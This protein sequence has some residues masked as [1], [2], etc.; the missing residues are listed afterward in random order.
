M[1]VVPIFTALIRV[2]V[3]RSMISLFSFQINAQALLNPLVGLLL[4]VESNVWMSFL[5]LLLV[6]LIPQIDMLLADQVQLF[7]MIIIIKLRNISLNC[8]QLLVVLLWLVIIHTLVHKY[9]LL[10]VRQLHMLT[11]FNQISRVN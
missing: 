9:L 6:L 7:L 8:N 3:L 5:I 2:S 11:S 1:L 10:E 4:S